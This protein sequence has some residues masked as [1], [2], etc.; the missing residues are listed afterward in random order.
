MGW[1]VLFLSQSLNLV[2]HVK[3]LYAMGLGEWSQQQ[4]SDFARNVYG[5][6]RYFTDLPGRFAFPFLIWLGFNWDLVMGMIRQSGLD[7][8]SQGQKAKPKTG[9][10]QKC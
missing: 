6:C 2:F 3:T 1:C 7:A 8:E 10:K 9:R 5:F 4:Y